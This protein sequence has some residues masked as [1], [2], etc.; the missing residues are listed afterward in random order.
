MKIGEVAREAGLKKEL[1][2]HYLRHG[3]LPPSEERGLY[4]RR[5]LRLLQQIRLLRENHQLPLEVIRGLFERLDFDPGRIESLTLSES[6]C[7]RV[8]RFVASGDLQSH[9]TLTVDELGTHT[10]LSAVELERYLE[11][12]MVE[13]LSG[14]TD[15]RYSG[16][17]A[18]VVALCERGV[19]LGVPFESFRTIASYVRV[20]FDLASADFY[21]LPKGPIAGDRVLGDFFVRREVA[22]SFVQSVLNA[23]TQRQVGQLLAGTPDPGPALDA[24]IYQ[25]SPAFLRA[26]GIDRA[27]IAARD[28]LALDPTD[29]FRWLHNGR[30][31][32]HAGRY[33]EAAFFLEEALERWPDDAT[34]RSTFGRALVLSGNHERGCE[35]LARARTDVAEHALGDVCHALSLFARARAR[36]LAPERMLGDAARVARSA[37]SAC[38]ESD[39]TPFELLEARLLCGWLLVSLPLLYGLREEGLTML[40]DAHREIEDG[41]PPDGALPGARERLR[42]NAAHLVLGCYEHFADGEAPSGELPSVDALRLTICRLDPGSAFAE[43][44]FLSGAQS[45]RED[46]R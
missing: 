31:L 1:V 41:A 22:S 39:A 12:R 16:Y 3:L 15:E 8:T 5:Q 28:A 32:I 35:E 45:E 43:A 24:V 46:P 44:A 25:P 20:A 40:L 9:R 36:E 4:T 26:H 13:P 21:E 42:I 37:K 30:V 34:L 2:H 18:Q 38:V 23:L 19:E 10:S 7:Q 11:S 17:D 33:E 6:L 14:E 29:R 27:A